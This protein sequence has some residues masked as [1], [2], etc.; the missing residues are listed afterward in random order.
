MKQE[1]E[2][3][4]TVSESAT[5]VDEVTD[6]R[7]FCLIVDLGSITRAAR[8]L[9]ES[10]AT[11]SRRLARIEAAVGV[12][13]VERTTRAMR[14]TEDGVAYRERLGEV[15]EL[16]AAANDAARHRA[17]APS[18]V[19][20]VTSGPEFNALLAPVVAAFSAKFPAVRVEMLVTQTALD[21]DAENVD[22]AL[23]VSFQLP[24]SALIA[25]KVLPLDV[26]FAAA[27]SY[28][29]TH[30]AVR[31]IDDLKKHRFVS[32]RSNAQPVPLRHKGT[33]ELTTLTLEPSLVGTDM[34]FLVDL[35]CAGA[36]I[37]VVPEVA[38]RPRL[39]IGTLVRLLPDY[40]MQG[41]PSLYLL[42]R[43]NRFLAPKVRAFR[44]FV[45][46]ALRPKRS[47]S[48]R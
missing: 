39:A 16:L 32:L 6:L 7:A 44:E 2:A 38:I 29:R 23:R 25:H 22:V 15:L 21:L 28:L 19:L 17:Q 35:A 10:K 43:G 37:I 5:L 20:R 34:N 26:A 42:H 47:A 41:G 3:R 30:G 11:V 12:T 8:A 36:G 33:G 4:R 31:T 13:L 46:D 40:E 18:G 24:S 1:R 9:R 27:P 45:L 48:R 14:P